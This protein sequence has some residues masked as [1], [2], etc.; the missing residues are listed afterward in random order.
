LQDAQEKGLNAQKDSAFDDILSGAR[1]RGLGFAG[2]PLGE[3]AKYTATNYLPALANLKQSFNEKGT[4]LTDALN[5]L[6]IT[7]NQY[8]QTI[9]QSELDRDES[10]RQFNVAQQ[11]AAAER[12]AQAR[13]AAASAAP[14]FGGGGGQTAPQSVGQLQQRQ[15]G[16]FNF[17]G[18]NNQAISAGT[19]ASMNKIPIGTLLYQMAQSGDKYAASAYNQI[20]ANQGYYNAHP[21]ILKKEFSPLFWG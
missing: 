10:A 20:K 19:Y 3:Q 9:R 2:I 6:N 16:G 8:A 14:T 15:G 5:Q 17:V 18:A 1:Q 7:Q 13:A 21:E 11:A 12:A 4:S